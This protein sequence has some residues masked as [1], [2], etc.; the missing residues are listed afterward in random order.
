[1]VPLP[2]NQAETP[3]RKIRECACGMTVCPSACVMVADTSTDSPKPVRYVPTARNR[4]ERRA[5][6]RKMK[7]WGW[8]MTRPAHSQTVYSPQDAARLRGYGLVGVSE[9]AKL[10]P[11]QWYH[12]HKP[13]ELNCLGR[14][15]LGTYALRSV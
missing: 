2:K 11:G 5:N 7:T 15:M 4:H 9:D 8:A 10:K 13:H 14:R 1:M 3:Q 6:T 12:D